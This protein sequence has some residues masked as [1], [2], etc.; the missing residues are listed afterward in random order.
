MTRL[1]HSP[2]DMPKHVK[3]YPSL[4]QRVYLSK[5]SHL[6]GLWLGELDPELEAAAVGRV[7]RVLKVRRTNLQ[8]HRK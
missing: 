4:V 3:M 8:Q 6:R 1:R 2:R 5:V 7:D